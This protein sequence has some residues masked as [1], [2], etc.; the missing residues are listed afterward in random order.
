M[1]VMGKGELKKGVPGGVIDP[2]AARA[3]HAVKWRVSGRR[4]LTGGEIGFGRA[5]KV[6]VPAVWA[7]W[8]PRVLLLMQVLCFVESLNFERCYLDLCGALGQG[9][10]QEKNRGRSSLHVIRSDFFGFPFSF[11]ESCTSL[12]NYALLSNISV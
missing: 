3:S 5:S 12:T 6:L 8:L 11:G 10:K 9:K 4:V 1:N 7:L 2:I